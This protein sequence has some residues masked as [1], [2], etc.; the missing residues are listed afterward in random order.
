MKPRT[1]SGGVIARHGASIRAF[2]PAVPGAMGAR[3]RAGGS[4]IH[5]LNKFF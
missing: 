5:L 1:D 2:R 4:A 3:K